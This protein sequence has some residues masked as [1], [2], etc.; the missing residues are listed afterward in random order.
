MTAIRSEPESP[1]ELTLPHLAYQPDA[2]GPLAG[3]T[4]IDLTRHVS[5]GQLG[6][7][8]GDLGADVIKVEQPGK[9]DGLRR[10]TV[11]G[12]DA[13]WR[14]YG[15]N[16]RSITLD[17][18]SER[19]REVFRELLAR[20]DVL[21][22]NFTPGV[23][24]QIV[25][26]MDEL[27]AQHPKLVVVRISGWGQT[28]PRAQRPGFG[29]LAEAYSGFTY[30]N[31]YDERSPLPPPLSLADTVAGTYAASAALAALFN[32]RAN[33][34]PG[35][36]VDISLFEPLF[37]I[38]GPDS[39]MYAASGARRYRGEGT[40]VSSVRGAFETSDGEWIVISAATPDIAARFF[41]GIG[42]QDVLEDERFATPQ[43]RLQHRQE[44]NQILAEEFGKRTRDEVM[45][46]AEEHRVTIGPV[47][48]IVDI[49][50]DDHYKARNSVV[51]MIEDDGETVVMPHPVPRLSKTPATIRRPA[52]GIGQDNGDVY[53]ELGF[54]AEQI[55]ELADQGV[56]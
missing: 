1:P 31:G 8:L 47:Y 14:A 20:A 50:D 10:A 24:E 52:P 6:L 35:Q 29:T 4:V 12:F 53:G 7:V 18:R 17:L 40:K 54:T 48:N 27:L 45:A 23:L 36:V 22:E 39:T 21:T 16:K 44:L 5:G 19:G 33:G 2:V 49:L 51:Q 11:D 15:R 42:R 56:I 34:G 3:V 25:G 43:G 9:G 38:M 13:Y 26:S 37:S 30:L 41:V 46:F 55:A 28:G 32:V